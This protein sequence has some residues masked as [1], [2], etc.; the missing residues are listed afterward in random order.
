MSTV[1]ELTGIGSLG[2][3]RLQQYAQNRAITNLLPGPDQ[4][5]Q[6][7]L[8]LPWRD[9]HGGG[10]KRMAVVSSSQSWDWRGPKQLAKNC[11]V[12]SLEYAA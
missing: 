5:I 9:S 8:Q 1:A 12:R 7:Y 4:L 3:K 10:A 2:E 11:R 6:R